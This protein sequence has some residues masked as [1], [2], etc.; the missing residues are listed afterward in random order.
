MVLCQEQEEVEKKQAV[1]GP[2]TD[3]VALEIGDVANGLIVSLGCCFGLIGLD[4]TSKGTLAA[5]L[6][7]PDHLLPEAI[8]GG[9]CEASRQ[10]EGNVKVFVL[11]NFG[12]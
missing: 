7:I 4:L 11:F 9:C 1:T 2:D 8:P 6:L 3:R 5:S 12:Y 10:S